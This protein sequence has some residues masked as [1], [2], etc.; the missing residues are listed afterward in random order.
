MMKIE[1]EF[2]VGMIQ[3]SR[4]MLDTVTHI[5]GTNDKIMLT[6]VFIGDI[7]RLVGKKIRIT[8]EELEE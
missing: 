5:C 6:D 3:H 7:N 8:I 4:G 1:K 2:T